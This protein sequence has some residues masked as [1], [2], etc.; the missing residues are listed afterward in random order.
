MTTGENMITGISS[1]MTKKGTKKAPIKE[2]EKKE[3]PS[4][5][6]FDLN[7]QLPLILKLF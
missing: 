3:I 5:T 7:F 4:H 1:L 6:V 2:N